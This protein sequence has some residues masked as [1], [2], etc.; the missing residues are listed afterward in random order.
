MFIDVH[1]HTSAR[2]G[3]VRQGGEANYATPEYLM[4]RYDC[5]GIEKAVILPLTHPEC[6]TQIQSSEEALEIAE[7]YP[8]RFIPFCN[9]DPRMDSN[10]AN[11]DLS[12]FVAYYKAIGC[13]GCGEMC[14]NLPFDHPMMENL[15]SACE[16]NG[17][18]LTFHIAPRIGGCYGI[19]DDPGLPLLEGALKK[20]ANLIFLGHSQCFWA[21]ISSLEGVKDRNSYPK[22]PVTEGR[23]VELMRRYPNLHGD[24]SAGSGYNAVSRDERFGIRFMEEFQDRL[25][26]GTDICHPDT[27]TPLVD[28]LLRLR[29]EKSISEAV[30]KKIAHDNAVRLLCL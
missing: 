29:D 8:T 27:E 24:L 30:F 10:D 28:Y 11:A 16:K 17:L 22:G 25:Y 7:K 3:P 23:V 26:F 19:Y 20:F 2:P 9:V 18:P 1:V 5:L 4:R 13:R 12:R 15:F 14:A 21:E 6:S